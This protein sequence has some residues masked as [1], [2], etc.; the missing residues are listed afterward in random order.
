MTQYRFEDFCENPPDENLPPLDRAEPG[1]DIVM[2]PD[3]AHWREHGY[4]IL[5]K[6]MPDELIDAYCRVF[7]ATGRVPDGWGEPQ[8]YLHVPEMLDL[9]CHPPLLRK[10]EELIPTP[11][12]V[13]LA[14]TAWKSTTRT[15]HQ[16]DY[17]NPPWM[18][19]NMNPMANSIGTL[20]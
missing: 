13:N 2:T 4:L 12:A 8:P 14:L 20:R 3:A 7:K 15:W 9:C 16:D 17:L 5:P 11:M 10:I 6:F 19:V 18:N 1:N